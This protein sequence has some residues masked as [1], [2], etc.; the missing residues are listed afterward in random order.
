MIQREDFAREVKGE[1]APDMIRELNISML[2]PEAP[3][4][5]QLRKPDFQRETNHWK[6][7]QVLRLVKSF[8]DGD[9][10]PSIILWRSTNF[11][12]VIDGAHRLSALCAWLSDDYGSGPLS[13]AFYNGEISQEQK[14]IAERTRRMINK[15]VGSYIS[16]RQL[17]G[18]SAGGLAG[19]RAGAL[20]TR[21]IYLQQVVGTPR[22]A[23]DSFFAINT[24]GTALDDTEKFLIETRRKPISI[25]ARAIVR[26]GF[27]HHCCPVN[28]RI[29]SIG[30]NL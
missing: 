4:R 26:G 27:G 14:N 18:E 30:Y 10:I 3:I 5:R 21:P 20:F 2:L 19:Q 28:H 12:F 11:I 29:N 24:Q 6:P 17:V 7:D 1:S 9:V 23:E 25:G 15:D 16:I 22:V 13:N 8:I